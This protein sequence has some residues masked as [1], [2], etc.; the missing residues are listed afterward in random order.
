MIFWITTAG[1]MRGDESAETGRS[2]AP[3]PTLG[4]MQYW[5]DELFFHKWRIQ[6]NVFTGHYRLLDEK[7]RRHAWG[8]FDQCRAALEQ[9]KKEQ[10]LPPMNGKAVI[11]LH[12]L[13]SVRQWM[14]SLCVYLEEKGGYEVY[15]V[16]Y[17]STQYDIVEHSRSLAHIINNLEGVEELN[18]VGHS[19]GNVVVRCYLDELRREIPS[20]NP[21]ATSSNAYRGRRPP[22]HRF[23]ML[24]PPNHEAQL[25]T[26]LADNPLFKGV[27]GEVG[28][29]LGREFKQLEN[30]L[31]TPDFEFAIIA[32]GKN[33]EKGYNPLMPGDNDGIITVE[34]AKLDGARDFVVLPAL[35][36]L[37]MQYAQTQEY[38]LRFLKEGYFVSEEERRPLDKK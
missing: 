34:S 14:N 33:Q 16:S 38:T 13:A 8:T 25:A 28:R 35:H 21:E 27:T 24:A 6:R 17:P 4:G 12:G 7:D 19:L 5:A 26:S 15:N 10:N 20:K 18:F 37:I 9:I 31:A 3:M 32:G 2:L 23:V 36:P 11:V 1:Q 29:Q 30:K 22:F